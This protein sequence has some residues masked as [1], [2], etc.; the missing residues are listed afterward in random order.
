MST[1][2]WGNRALAQLSPLALVSRSL[3]GSDNEGKTHTNEQSPLVMLRQ[4]ARRH[5]TGLQ[6]S[7][8]NPIAA[9]NAVCPV[10]RE[11]T[12]AHVGH[13]IAWA[14]KVVQMNAPENSSGDLTPRSVRSDV[15]HFGFNGPTLTSICYEAPTYLMMHGPAI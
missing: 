11:S 13:A 10:S 4:N 1:C 5:L 14:H 6:F 3:R 2:F 7:L 15:D 9:L 8:E 12:H